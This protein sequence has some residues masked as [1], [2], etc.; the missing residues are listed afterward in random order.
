MDSSF[1]IYKHGLVKLVVSVVSVVVVV[2]VVLKVAVLIV[3]S[4]IISA[5]GWR[6]LWFWRL[7]DCCTHNNLHIIASSASLR[8]F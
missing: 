7:F 6:C 3:A 4:C 5:S 1:R 8:S 2:A